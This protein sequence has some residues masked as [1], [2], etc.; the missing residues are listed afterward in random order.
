MAAAAEEV[1]EL[2]IAGDAQP[3]APALFVTMDTPVLR[4]HLKLLS[5]SEMHE[6]ALERMGAE[7]GEGEGEDEEEEEEIGEDE[8]EDE[9]DDVDGEDDW[10]S[11]DD[12]TDGSSDV[13]TEEDNEPVLDVLHTKW[14]KSGQL[15]KLLSANLVEQFPAGPVLYSD[16]RDSQLRMMGRR[17]G[18][19]A[20]DMPIPDLATALFT[21]NQGH[22]PPTLPAALDDDLFELDFSEEVVPREYLEVLGQEALQR[23][24]RFQNIEFDVDN[25]LPDD[26]NEDVFY[27]Y[28]F[29][30]D[31]N[32]LYNTFKPTS[33]NHDGRLPTWRQLRFL[34]FRL[35]VTAQ[36]IIGMRDSLHSGDHLRFLSDTTLATLYNAIVG[37][38]PTLRT[39]HAGVKRPKLIRALVQ[40]RLHFAELESSVLKEMAMAM[41]T[42]TEDDI[43]E[44]F[45]F[46]DLVT[47]ASVEIIQYVP[48]SPVHLTD[49]TFHTV[50]VPGRWA[51]YFQRANWEALPALC[52]C[53]G[54]ENRDIRER[55]I[56]GAHIRLL[57]TGGRE[58]YGIVIT[59]AACNQR[60]N[61]DERPPTGPFKIVTILGESEDGR[62]TIAGS[63]QVR[64][65]GHVNTFQFGAGFAARW[66][67]LRITL[68]ATGQAPWRVS[69][70]SLGPRSV[71]ER[72]ITAF[73]ERGRGSVRERL[74][75]R[76]GLRHVPKLYLAIPENYKIK[77][78]RNY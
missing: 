75:R 61:A 17:Y 19:D 78:P 22:N 53:R 9:E 26:L 35:Q 65:D 16:L 64:N 37:R 27:S 30:E 58:I 70:G 8:D 63:A 54:C 44:D 68:T 42:L 69:R 21:M 5:L 73:L 14:F 4:R 23:I 33:R 6:L 20:Q 29:A 52:P 2:V 59:C 60:D 56:R 7:G 10:P 3:P 48:E 38:Q 18:L 77:G 72:F 51:G 43:D 11:E 28:L 47:R 25:D 50:N 55:P 71:I 12:S 76:Q 41:G 15:A 36:C 24:L 57:A 62:P 31:I 40:R 49:S 46:Q 45:T 39:H 32:T 74:N 13:N 34:Y 66:G 1:P 67:P